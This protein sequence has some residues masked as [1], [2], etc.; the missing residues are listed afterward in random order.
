MGIFVTTV[1]GLI[2]WL[3]LHQ[4]FAYIVIFL[5]AYFETVIGTAFFIPGEIFFLSGSILAGAGV[6]RIGLVVPIC[7]IGS[8][9]GDSSSY[10]IGRKIG[11]SIFR[12]GRRI[13]NPEN[14]KKG[15][16]FFNRY[17][18]KAVFFARLLGPLS[19]ITPFLVGTYKVPYRKFLTYNILGVIVGVG[20]FLAV[21]YFFGK[22]YVVIL[23]FIQNYVEIIIGIAILFFIG[24]WYLKKSRRIKI[25]IINSK[26]I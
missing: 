17:G 7:Y 8:I 1:T 13:L 15:E 23:P 6:L 10:F 3:S 26:K 12:D 24:R 5:G 19:W 9:M 11:V 18:A 25:A 2:D 22:Q 4:Q 20:E 21:G 16:D 14:Y